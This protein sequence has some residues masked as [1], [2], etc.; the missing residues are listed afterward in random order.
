MPVRTAAENSDA[1]SPV[2]ISWVF[3]LT[4]QV[5]WSLKTVLNIPEGTTS[6]NGGRAFYVP[7]LWGVGRYEKP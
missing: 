6:V 4:Q 1:A 3:A 7:A 2:G 5:L